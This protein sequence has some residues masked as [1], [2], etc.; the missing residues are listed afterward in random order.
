MELLDGIHLLRIERQVLLDRG[1][2]GGRLFIAPGRILPHE[3]T[4]VDGEV[5][6]IASCRVRAC[7]VSAMMKPPS[8]T[9]M[10]CGFFV[11]VIG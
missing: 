5:G 9:R 1:N 7:V 10:R 11:M 2:G 8:M 6:G 4:S 3:P